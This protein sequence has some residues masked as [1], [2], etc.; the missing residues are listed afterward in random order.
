MFYAAKHTL[1]DE[2]DVLLIDSDF[3][4]S[5][6]EDNIEYRDLLNKKRPKENEVSIF[7]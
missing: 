5:D 2:D 6:E 3:R 7:T 4:F 1:E